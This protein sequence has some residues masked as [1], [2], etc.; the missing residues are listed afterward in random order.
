M[1]ETE[2][3]Q[4]LAQAIAETLEKMFFV[5]WLD[6]PAAGATSQRE[7]AARLEFEGS[8]SGRLTLRIAAPA[9]RSIAADFLGETELAPSERRVEEVIC[10]LANMICGSVLS[11]VENA[12]DFRLGAPRL[13][14]SAGLV[15]APGAVAHA[16]ET[17][18]GLIEAVLEMDNLACPA[19]PKSAS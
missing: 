1:I 6:E 19:P 18:G 17:G 11:R 5:S 2:L 9:A 3:R 7:F 15:R 10:E 12:R 8:P 16:V 14:P 4:A 13:I